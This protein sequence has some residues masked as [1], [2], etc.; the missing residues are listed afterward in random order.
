M[1]YGQELLKVIRKQ[2]VCYIRTVDG[3]RLIS[4]HISYNQLEQE[5]ERLSDI[6]GTENKRK[7]RKEA[8]GDSYLTVLLK[9]GECQPI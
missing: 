1:D 3:K 2:K 6:I 7:M 4:N 5:I 8:E 9:R